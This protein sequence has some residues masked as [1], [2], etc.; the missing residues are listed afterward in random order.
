M[1]KKIK[2]KLNTKLIGVYEVFEAG[3]ETGQADILETKDV[4]KTTSRIN[5]IWLAHLD[6]CWYVHQD[7]AYGER[8][9]GFGA[10][11]CPSDPI[12][13]IKL[14]VDGKI[15]EV[16]HKVGKKQW[17]ALKQITRPAGVAL[18]TSLEIRNDD[19]IKAKKIKIK[20]K[21]AASCRY[22]IVGGRAYRVC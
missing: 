18:E 5:L 3:T 1:A 20:M 17:D 15:S 8:W 7:V 12:F 2:I 19:P 6:G 22:V 9:W 11:P 16:E 21:F 14:D 10:R 4:P 13:R